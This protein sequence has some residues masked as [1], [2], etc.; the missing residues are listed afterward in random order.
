MSGTQAGRIRVNALH[1]AGAVAAVTLGAA[2]AWDLAGGAGALADHWPV[3][4][5]ALIAV[6]IAAGTSAVLIRVLRTRTGSASRPL[7]TLT[8]LAATGALL[9]AWMLR[10]HREIP[11]DPPLVALQVVAAFA[12]AGAAWRRRVLSRPG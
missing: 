11:P 6:A 12:W 4:S 9:G 1:A 5:H 2:I 7:I 3:V 10:G 8:E